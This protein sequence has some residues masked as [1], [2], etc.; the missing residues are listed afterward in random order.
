M[1]PATGSWRQIGGCAM[2]TADALATL[3]DRLLALR[4][5]LRQRLAAD[6]LDA[7]LLA[8]LAHA[9]IALAALARG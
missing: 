7:G 6:H 4:D 8:M 9:E 3:R 1:A 5:D 2:T